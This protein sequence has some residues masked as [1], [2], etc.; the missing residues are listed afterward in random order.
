M[1]NN[2]TKAI[3]VRDMGRTTK[4]VTSNGIKNVNYNYSITNRQGIIKKC[5]T[6]YDK[7][8]DRSY[9]NIKNRLR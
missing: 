1:V 7:S 6:T 5:K 9:D 3:V 8:F 4:S 2:S